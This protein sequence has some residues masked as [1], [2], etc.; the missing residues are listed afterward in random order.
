MNESGICEKFYIAYSFLT[1]L[2]RAFIVSHE[3]CDLDS[4]FKIT[5]PDQKV[6]HCI[7]LQIKP[8]CLG[9]IPSWSGHI[10]VSL[11]HSFIRSPKLHSRK[12]VKV[13]WIPRCLVDEN[14]EKEEYELGILVIIC[15][16][17]PYNQWVQ[18]KIF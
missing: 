16:I 6:K 3:I 9:F 17:I 12:N 5:N 18:T 10:E 4:N 11:N 15:N 1:R 2:N 8:I 13:S 14:N 7:P